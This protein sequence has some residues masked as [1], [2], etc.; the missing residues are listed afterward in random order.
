MCHASD[1][2]ARGMYF[3]HMHVL[4]MLRALRP[5]QNHKSGRYPPP[6]LAAWVSK[7]IPSPSL[8][9]K[10][11]PALGGPKAPKVG[12]FRD[13][14]G[15]GHFPSQKTDSSPSS[16]HQGTPSPQLLGR[17]AGRSCADPSPSHLHKGSKE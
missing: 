11:P 4:S 14:R 6:H 9:E 3:L 1:V 17:L 12:G 13:Q 7:W 2:P 16:A 10:K 8:S 15:G 5:S